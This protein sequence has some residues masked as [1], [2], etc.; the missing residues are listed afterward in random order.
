M[1]TRSQKSAVTVLRTSRALA[2]AP[3]AVPQPM[4]KDASAGLVLPQAGHVSMEESLQP[5][6]LPFGPPPPCRVGVRMGHPAMMRK[7]AY[8]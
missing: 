1:P 3:R 7:C 5:A 2:V 4:Q 8:I 6:P